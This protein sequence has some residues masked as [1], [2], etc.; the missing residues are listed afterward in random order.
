MCSLRQPFQLHNIQRPST[1]D[2][3]WN[4]SHHS[5]TASTKSDSPKL[6]LQWLRLHIMMQPQ[7]EPWRSTAWLRAIGA[8]ALRCIQFES[9]PASGTCGGLLRVM[10]SPYYSVVPWI[11]IKPL[12]H[13][14]EK[15]SELVMYGDLSNN[16]SL[17]FMRTWCPKSL[18]LYNWR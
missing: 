9:G 6:K 7:S 12:S 5:R 8:N 14:G 18:S 2:F 11:C 10:L 1:D 4:Y 16:T 15:L 13:R 3:T 17:C